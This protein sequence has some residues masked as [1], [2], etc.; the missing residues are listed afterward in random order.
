MRRPL[1]LPIVPA[2]LPDGITLAAFSVEAVRA[3]RELMKRVYPGGLG[4]GNISFEGFWDWLTNDPEYDP[5]L[6][7]VA[8]ANDAVIGFCH[9]WRDAFVKDL[10]VDAAFRQRGLG[11][12]LL[13]TA[14]KAFAQRG[15]EFV[16]LKTDVDNLVAQ[17]LYKRLGFVIVERLED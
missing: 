5:T 13:T 12:A 15:A 3:R 7:F 8:T 14:L 17:W 4:D 16:D 10:V 1:S 6:M 2:A 11:T 9:C